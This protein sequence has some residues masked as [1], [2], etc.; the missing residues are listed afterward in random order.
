[1][2]DIHGSDPAYHSYRGRGLPGAKFLLIRDGIDFATRGRTTGGYIDVG[3][4][5]PGTRDALLSGIGTFATANV[6]GD[7]VMVVKPG[8]VLM[9][10]LSSGAL[11]GWVNTVHT[12]FEAFPAS[13]QVVATVRVDGTDYPWMLAHTGR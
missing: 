4:S 8:G 5:P 12:I 10:G 6:T 1:M 7:L 9:N 3:C 2:N 11:S 13:F